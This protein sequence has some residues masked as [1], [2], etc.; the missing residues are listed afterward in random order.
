MNASRAAF[1]SSLEMFRFS[2][3]YFRACSSTPSLN[4]KKIFC[5]ANFLKKNIVADNLIV[6]VEFFNTYFVVQ[7][8]SS[9]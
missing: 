1:V 2:T 4:R 7:T 9:S 6:L 5:S 8:C 3:S